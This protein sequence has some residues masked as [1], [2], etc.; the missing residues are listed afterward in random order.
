MLQQPKLNNNVFIRNIT[1]NMKGEDGNVT[2]LSFCTAMQWL[3]TTNTETKIK[4]LFHLLNNG[5]SLSKDLLQ[6]VLAKIYPDDSQESLTV[7]VEVFFREMDPNNKGVIEEVD[8]VKWARNIPPDAKAEIFNFEIIPA[9]IK[10]LSSGPD[11]T[12]FKK[13][14]HKRQSPEPE[15]SRQIPTDYK[16]NEIAGKIY[17][18]DWYLV[19]NKLGF[20]STDIN[21]FE[22]R[23]PDHKDTAFFMLKSWRNREGNHAYAINLEKAL[24]DSGMNDVAMLLY[25]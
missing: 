22:L 21:E 14:Q 15:F 11:I 18:R 13:S 12:G 3:E 8:F 16:L 1:K 10:E 7:L 5:K 20:T 23:F 2:F 24:R 25:P 17:R 6:K 19:A 4:A 9:D